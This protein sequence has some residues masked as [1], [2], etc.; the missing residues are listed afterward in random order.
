MLRLWRLFLVVI[1]RHE[2]PSFL[3]GT[4]MFLLLTRYVEMTAAIDCYFT[5]SKVSSSDAPYF[6]VAYNTNVFNIMGAWAFIVGT[7][8]CL[9]CQNNCPVA[10]ACTKL[11][12]ILRFL[13]ILLSSK[14]AFCALMFRIRFF[15][16][17]WQHCL[18]GHVSYLT[19]HVDGHDGKKSQ[20]FNALLRVIWALC[21]RDIT[22]A[23]DVAVVR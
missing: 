12:K 1:S 6:S 11:N 9:F 14:K 18:P 23:L 2:L 4:E 7:A 19:W 20:H 10:M 13:L 22:I 21:A 5:R 15:S 17:W 16:G 3:Q 8:V